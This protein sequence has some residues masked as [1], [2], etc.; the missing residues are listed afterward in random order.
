M[1]TTN[2]ILFSAAIIIAAFFLGNAYVEKS[3]RTGT[4]NVTGLGSK[5]FVSDLIVWDG[6]Y[7]RLD[8]DLKKA[9]VLLEQDKKVITRYLMEKGIKQDEIVFKAVETR[10]QNE[11]K[12]ENGDYVGDEFI[13][14]E[15]LQVVEIE[16]ADVEG[17]EELS[18]SITELLNEGVTFY[19]NPP[20]Y[21]YTKLSDLKVEMIRMATEDAKIRAETIASNSGGELDNLRSANMGVFQITGQ[22]S[23]EDYSWGGA[24]NTR[25]KNKT[26]SITM[27]LVYDISD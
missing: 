20:R 27:R 5:D 26:A 11:R 1:K 3:Q 19:S 17:V 10:V 22:N 8:K 13:G 14:H 15:L 2:A 24:F 23:N 16:S 9:Y 7:S 6:R 25:D 18:R 4:I 12:Y 21:Y